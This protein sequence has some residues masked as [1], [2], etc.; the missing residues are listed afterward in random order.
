[1]LTGLTAIPW[2]YPMLEVIHILGIATLLG[3][4]L[5]LEMR[6][7]GLAS[8]LPIKEVAR[9]SLGLAVTGFCIAACSGL[10]MFATQPLEL[11]NNGAF[12]LKMLFLFL[13]A[14]NAGW[15]HG[16]GSLEKLDAIAKTQMVVSSLIWIAVATCGRWIAYK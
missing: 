15:F 10:M 1:M 2:L 11:I 12:K 9:L 14:C 8:A 16:R 7:L 6:V 13:A 5:F 4:L 3:N